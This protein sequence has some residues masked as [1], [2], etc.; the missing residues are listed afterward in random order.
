V[1]TDFPGTAIA[2]DQAYREIDVAIDFCEDVPPL[3]LETAQEIARAFHAEGAE[4]KVSSIHVNAWF[5][6]HDKLTM[7]SRFLAEVFDIRVETDAGAVAYCGDSPNDA[8]MFA[9]FPLSI[10]VANIK[11]YSALM[12]HLP[13]FVT[14][15]AGG[16]GFA[17]FASA[18]IRAK[19]A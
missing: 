12:A 10:G 4:A 3:P 18:V 8:P 1:L 14:K 2:S 7:S 15:A 17:E 6:Q 11:P 16:I 5:G 19:R 13:R 9:G